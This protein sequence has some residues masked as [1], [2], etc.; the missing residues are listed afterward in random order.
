M[1]CSWNTFEL[2]CD[3]SVLLFINKYANDSNAVLIFGVGLLIAFSGVTFFTKPS[4]F[5]YDCWIN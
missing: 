5:N 2:E 1:Y 3:D 4:V